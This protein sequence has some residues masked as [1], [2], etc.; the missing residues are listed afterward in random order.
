MLAKNVA[1]AALDAYKM[2]ERKMKDTAVKETTHVQT[3][4]PEPYTHTC[5]HMYIYIYIEGGGDNSE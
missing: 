4:L 5:I 2:I 3:R 1:T